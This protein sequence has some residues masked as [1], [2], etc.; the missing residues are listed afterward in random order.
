MRKTSAFRQIC[1]WSLT[2]CLV[3][4]VRAG[5]AGE[6]VASSGSLRVALLEL[7]TSEGCD[8]C[9]PADRWV[10]Q[11]PAKKLAADRLLSLAFHVDYWNQLGWRDAFSQ[12]AF[13]ERQREQSRRRAVGFVVT[14]Q[15]LL[16]GRDYRRGV[17]FDDIEATVRGINR[18]SPAAELSMRAINRG[19]SIEST[20]EVSLVDGVQ[21][22]SQVYVALYENN[23]L[24]AI[25]AGENKGVTLKHDYVV[26]SLVG[27]LM[28][29]RAHLSHKQDFVLQ[30][31]WKGA[32]LRLAAFVQDPRT[33]DVLQALSMQCP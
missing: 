12:A 31:D 10:A 19:S 13:S 32:D 17:L 16:N 24:S 15:L 27:P 9:P 14:P 21:Q 18:S 3:M 29:R 28:M 22:D 8:S 7:Y 25:K 11:L 1:A 33:G 6:C 23:L 20:I 5:A 30:S 4:P 26:R 2:A